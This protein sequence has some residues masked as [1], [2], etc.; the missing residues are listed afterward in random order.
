MN[1]ISYCYV[2]LK[3]HNKK[4]SATG[5]LSNFRLFIFDGLLEVLMKLLSY[6]NPFKLMIYGSKCDLE[7]FK[8]T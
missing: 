4:I 6:R 2:T 1:V 5:I 8:Y 3:I 7:E